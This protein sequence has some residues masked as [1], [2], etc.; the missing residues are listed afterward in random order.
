MCFVAQSGKRRTGQ[1]IEG[2]APGGSD[3]AVG[4]NMAVAI[5][6]RGTA[7]RAG[8]RNGLLDDI[9]YALEWGCRLQQFQQAPVGA[10]SECRAD[11]PT[12]RT[13]VLA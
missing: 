6:F 10:A 5:W 13:A 3:S 12:V 1:R 8:R 9:K 11:R 7:V 4:L 2:A